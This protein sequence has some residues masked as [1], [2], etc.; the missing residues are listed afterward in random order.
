MRIFRAKV[1]TWTTTA[2]TTSRTDEISQEDSS[3]EIVTGVTLVAFV[4]DLGPLTDGDPLA[5]PRF[6]F[7]Q[8]GGDRFVI[9]NLAAFLL[10]LKLM[11]EIV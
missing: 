7:A 2:D 9:D 4:F 8:T 5:I 10:P 1:A 6:P 11:F 3:V